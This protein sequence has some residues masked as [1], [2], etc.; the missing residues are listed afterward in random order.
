MEH[1][2]EK[3]NMQH[4]LTNIQQS[5]VWRQWKKEKTIA[6]D[7]LRYNHKEEKRV[8]E[9]TGESSLITPNGNTPYSCP[10]RLKSRPAT[11]AH[12][13]EDGSLGDPYLEYLRCGFY[14]NLISSAAGCWNNHQTNAPYD[15]HQVSL[16]FENP[17]YTEATA[18][19]S[20]AYL[21]SLNR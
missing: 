4:A 11:V 13:T 21:E 16:T 8:E 2:V 1:L 18:L 6:F 15:L 10:V 5:T 12:T 19:E 14:E 3:I 9:Y 20:V 17:E 7:K